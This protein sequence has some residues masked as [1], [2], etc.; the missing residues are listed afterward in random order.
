LNPV[1]GKRH[2]GAFD[3]CELPAGH[4]RAPRKPL[5]QRSEKQ[6]VKESEWQAIKRRKVN[7]QRAIHGFTFCERCGKRTKWLQCHHTDYRSRGGSNTE[8]NAEL[9]CT[10]PGSCHEREHGT[11]WPKDREDPEGT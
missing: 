11:P 5:R 9:L 6:E 7:R 10:G 4:D 1:C 3:R 8:D 2:L